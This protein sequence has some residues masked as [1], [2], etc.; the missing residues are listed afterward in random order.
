[1]VD[2]TVPDFVDPATEGPLPGK[3]EEDWD[4]LT[5]YRVVLAEEA[6]RWEAAERLQRQRVDWIR[7]RAAAIL[8][9]SPKE[10][11]AGEKNVARTLSVSRHELSEIQR[12]QGPQSAWKGI[13][14]RWPSR[15]RSKTS[16]WQLAV[17]ST[18]N[19]YKNL[20]EIRD[21]ALA[22][23]WYSRSLELHPKGDR[24]GRAKCLG[25]LGSVAYLRFLDAREAD[26]TAHN[27]LGVVYQ[28]AGQV[29]AALRHYRQSIR[30]KETMQDRYEAGKTRRNAARA[31]AVAGRLADAREWAR[32]AL[33]DYQASE[34]ADQE[35]VGTLKLLEWIESALQETPPPS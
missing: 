35:A 5:H 16:K 26:Q 32:A 24:L 9:R 29:D 17:H 30:Y 4:L 19:A 13:A 23:Q 8:A 3:K 11:D 25:Q 10:W 20:R 14:K 22:E 7:Q 31:L 6:R 1:L 2:E 34:N 18:W 15:N 12:E 21:F 27:Q 33:R 28:S